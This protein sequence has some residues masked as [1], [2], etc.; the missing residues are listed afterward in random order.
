VNFCF[1]CLH[2]A[3]DH[4]TDDGCTATDNLGN[5]CACEHAP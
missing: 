5:R 3:R 2:E 4:T 1:G